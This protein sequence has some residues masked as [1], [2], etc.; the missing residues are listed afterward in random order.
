MAKALNIC[1]RKLKWPATKINALKAALKIYFQMSGAGYRMAIHY[2]TRKKFT[3]AESAFAEENQRRAVSGDARASRPPFG[4][5]SPMR[6]GSDCQHS[7][8]RVKYIVH[9]DSPWSFR[10]EQLFDGRFSA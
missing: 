9:R 10:V 2:L 3:S 8:S 4:V 5:C 7:G 6:S 1:A